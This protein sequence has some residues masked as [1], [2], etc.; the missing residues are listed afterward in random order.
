ML[1]DKEIRISLS[2]WQMWKN[3]PTTQAVFEAL[4]NERSMWVQALAFGDTLQSP[5]NEMKE[6]AKAVG[7]VAGLS[8]LLDD[9]EV[10]IATQIA[11]AEERR[12]EMEEESE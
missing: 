11:E 4:S 8:V 5:G 7:V 1:S 3:L 6:T 10:A 12:K 2:E 9:L